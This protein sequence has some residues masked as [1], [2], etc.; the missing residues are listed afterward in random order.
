LKRLKKS[1]TKDEKR[2]NEHAAKAIEEGREAE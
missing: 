2:N 1:P